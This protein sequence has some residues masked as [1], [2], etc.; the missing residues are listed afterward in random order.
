ME[1]KRLPIVL[2]P[3]R[4]SFAAAKELSNRM[5]ESAFR[6]RLPRHWRGRACSTRRQHMAIPP[7]GRWGLDALG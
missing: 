1:A 4:A 7:V 3:G 2:K 5:S 6:E